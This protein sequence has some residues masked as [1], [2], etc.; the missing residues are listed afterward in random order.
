MI[1][2]YVKTALRNLLRH[3]GV[4]FLHLLG[5]TSAFSFI[6]LIAAYIRSETQV[7]KD[8]HQIERQ[9][10]LQSSINPLTAYGGMAPALKEN[11]PDLVE[12]YFRFDGITAIVTQGNT[13]HQLSAMIADSSFFSMFGFALAEGNA[14][15]ALTEPTQVVLTTPTAL[16]LFGKTDVIGETLQVANFN[17]EKQAFTVSGVLEPL[18]QNSVLQLIDTE[19]SEI[20]FPVSSSLYFNRSL[21]SWYNPYIASYLLL[22]PGITPQE[23]EQPI[24]QLIQAHAPEEV[25]ATLTTHLTPL[26]SYY[27][28]KDEGTMGKMLWTIGL[29]GSFILLMALINYTNLTVQTAASRLKEIGVRKAIGGSV[30]QLRAQFLIE[31]VLL[32]CIAGVLAIAFYPLLSGLSVPMF[33]KQVDAL[34]QWEGRFWVQIFGVCLLIGLIAGFYPA[35]KLSNVDT[36]LSVKGKQP[37]SLSKTWFLKGLVVSQLSI[38]LIVLIGATVIMAQVKLFFGNNLG[39]NQDQLLM[40]QVPRDWTQEGLQKMMMKQDRLR[41]NPHIASISLSYDIPT[42]IHTGMEK[43]QKS[44]SDQELIYASKVVSDRYFTETYQIPLLAGDFYSKDASSENLTHVVINKTFSGAL[45]YQNPEDAIQKTLYIENNPRALVIAGV[46]DDFYSHSLHTASGPMIWYNIK[47]M[48]YYRFM[49]IRLK[50]GPLK[51]SLA[52]IENQWKEMMPDAPF[53]F[54]FADQRLEALYL[55]E[56]RLEQTAKTAAFLAF[57]IVFLGLVGLITQQL[58]QRTKEIGI[59]KVL[60]ASILQV[61]GL[62]ARELSKTFLIAMLIALPLAYWMMDRWLTGYHLKTSVDLLKMGGPVIILLLFI[63]LLL[64]FQ[65]WRTAKANPVKNLREE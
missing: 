6:I 29:V 17:G 45:G 65:T 47:A 4:T 57:L 14:L 28:E 9:Y 25:R 43:Y 59:R 36:V 18:R 64:F 32:V 35:F 34:H 62:F 8:L 51:A 19:G 31:S 22:K 63:S 13:P 39:Y 46:V 52:S 7:N 2:N 60:G 38:A 24:Q 56:L 42:A 49:S 53:A 21:D 23:L 11:Y 3:R 37:V 40:V 12:D 20:L 5:L 41:E 33:G 1:R 10:L 27:L 30:T 48:P 50:D 26:Q 54:Q 58:V 55:T 15:T 61:I 44:T 16:K